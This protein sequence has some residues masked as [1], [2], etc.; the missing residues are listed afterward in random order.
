MLNIKDFIFE[1]LHINKNTGND[2]INFVFKPK[3]KDSSAKEILNLTV[4][5][6]FNIIVNNE[7]KITIEKIQGE[8]IKNYNLDSWNLYDNNNKAIINLTNDGIKKLL[9]SC[10]VLYS[11][12]IDSNI[13]IDPKTLY[14]NKG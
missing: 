14:I 10:D 13:K 8:Y 6:P 1:R 5:L 3:E 4:Y 11:S 2:Y 12:F 7:K 9:I